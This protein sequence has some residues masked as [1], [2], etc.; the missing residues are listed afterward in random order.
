[1]KCWDQ[2]WVPSLFVNE[3]YIK[4]SPVKGTTCKVEPTR[5]QYYLNSIRMDCAVM[6]TVFQNS[7]DRHPLLS[8]ILRGQRFPP[9]PFR[10]SP[11]K[12]LRF[13]SPFLLELPKFLLHLVPALC[14]R[15]SSTSDCIPHNDANAVPAEAGP[16]YS[17]SV[18]VTRNPRVRDRACFI[19]FTALKDTIS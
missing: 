17:A 16:L 7:T 6:P 1:M 2:K 12:L 10:Y 11:F 9:F 14:Q 8:T 18:T 19:D 5:Q 4:R 15:P 13:I 3:V